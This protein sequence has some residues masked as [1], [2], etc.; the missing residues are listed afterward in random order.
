MSESPRNLSDSEDAAPVGEVGEE[1]SIGTRTWYLQRELNDIVRRL[2]EGDR[3]LS[4]LRNSDEAHTKELLGIQRQLETKLETIRRELEAKDVTNRHD[5]E[6]LISTTRRELESQIASSLREVEGRQ[7]GIVQKLETSLTGIQS[8]FMTLQDKV[9]PRVTIWRVLGWIA[10]ILIPTGITIGGWLWNGSRYPERE[11]FR[12]LER[13]VNTSEKD[14]VDIR[15]R[16][17]P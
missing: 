6:G 5:I 14:I 9:N 1:Q 3:Q 10:V 15:A 17:K 11:E 12:E 16:V 7:S 2:K 8:S 13:R 4:N